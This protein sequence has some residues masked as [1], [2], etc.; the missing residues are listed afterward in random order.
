MYLLIES[1]NKNKSQIVP[2][3]EKVKVFDELD[4]EMSIAAIRCQFEVTH[5]ITKI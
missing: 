4:R 3:L 5:H 2:V 1:K